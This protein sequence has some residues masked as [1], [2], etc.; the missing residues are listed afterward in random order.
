MSSPQEALSDWLRRASDPLVKVRLFASSYAPLFAI[1][2]IRLEGTRLRLT[3]LLVAIASAYSAVRLVRV[4]AG[5]TKRSIKIVEV[6]DQGAEVAAYVGTYLLPFLMVPQ[7]TGRDLVA[8]ACFVAVVGV[9]YVR[10]SLIAI[11]PLL[12]ILNYRLYSAVTEQVRETKVSRRQVLLIT[13][14]VR[15]EDGAVSVTD[16]ADGVLLEVGA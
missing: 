12:Y 3:L 15:R 10:S 14:A 6:R 5:I 16:L 13:K 8:Y 1:A 9:V 4:S 2:A 11:N 7:P